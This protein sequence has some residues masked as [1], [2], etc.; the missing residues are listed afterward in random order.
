MIYNTDR[1]FGNLV[2][3]N[4]WRLWM[5]DH[6]RAF[7]LHRVWREP[8]QL[9]K[10]GRAF[11]EAMRRLRRE[12]AERRL[13][14]YLRPGEIDGLLARRDEIVRF[15]DAKAAEAGEEATLID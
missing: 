4:D 6:T 10:C 5:I 3:T 11:L 2:I 13:G 8:K 7:R 14:D 1:N 12:D 15:F 9:V